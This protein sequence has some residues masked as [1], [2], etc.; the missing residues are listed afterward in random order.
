MS[1]FVILNSESGRTTLPID[2]K[3]LKNGIQRHTLEGTV[4]TIFLIKASQIL[5]F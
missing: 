1:H 4:E 3:N 5:K 2:T